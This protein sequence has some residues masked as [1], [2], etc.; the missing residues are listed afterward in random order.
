MTYSRSPMRDHGQDGG[1]S[2]TSSVFSAGQVRRRPM[3]S[4]QDIAEAY[5]VLRTVAPDQDAADIVDDVE[6]W[7]GD[8]LQ[9]RSAFSVAVE[10]VKMTRKPVAPLP[11]PEENAR[12]LD[13]AEG[14]TAND[15]ALAEQVAAM[16]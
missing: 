6:R 8:R 1:E 16:D 14:T 13:Q 15:A 12:Q 4:D 7:M 2:P 5:L 11:T 3:L 9:H 10:I